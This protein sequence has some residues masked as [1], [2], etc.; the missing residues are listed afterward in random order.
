MTNGR[1]K[2]AYRSSSSTER[3]PLHL[4][5]DW[6]RKYLHKSPYKTLIHLWRK[7]AH[8]QTLRRE[9]RKDRI[10]FLHRLRRRQQQQQQQHVFLNS[11]FLASHLSSPLSF[12]LGCR[13]R[14]RSPKLG[15]WNEKLLA[16]KV[17]SMHK[18][19]TERTTTDFIKSTSTVVRHWKYLSQSHAPA[20]AHSL[21]L[22]V[23]LARKQAVW[24][25]SA[26]I[27]HLGKIV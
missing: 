13:G 24:T 4:S 5:F 3:T 22:S 7:S 10:T 2:R 12:S 14:V 21:F 25:D 1:S 6:K 16:L 9:A 20:H 27:C 11:S 26:N 18:T 23:M 15:S 19:R 17:K 8:K